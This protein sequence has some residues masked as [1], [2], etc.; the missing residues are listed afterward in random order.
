MENNFEILSQ[1]LYELTNKMEE[2]QYQLENV[3][4]KVDAIQNKLED[5]DKIVKIDFKLNL[6]KFNKC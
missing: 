2:I 5:D 4:D 3:M 1:Q 6:A